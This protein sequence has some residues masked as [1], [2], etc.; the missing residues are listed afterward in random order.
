MKKIYYLF[1]FV[2]LAFTACQKEPTLHSVLPLT[3]GEQSKTLTITLQNSDYQLLPSANYASTAFS[4]KNSADAQSG[5]AAILTAEY[6]KV[7]STSTAAVTYTQSA[8]SF[9]LAD[10]VIADDS[11]TLT[12]DDYLLLPGNKYTD[13]SVSQ[14]LQWLPY[15]FPNPANNTLKLITFTIYPASTT[16]VMPY[17]FLY[18]NNKWIEI[19]T[20]QP[21][22]YTELGLGKYD[23]F[24]SS[25]QNIP[26][27]LGAL[28]NADVT[29]TDTIKKGDIVYV[30]YNYYAGSSGD[31]QRVQPLEYN[32][33][34]FEV[35][36]SFPVTINFTKK[37][38]SWA[39]V[40]PLP[41]IAHT[42]T[43][44]D[45]TLITKSTVATPSLLSN[46]AQYGDFDS[47][48]TTSYL[49]AAF[50]LVLQADYPTPVINTNYEVTFN[51]YVGGSDVATTYSYQWSGTTWVPQQQ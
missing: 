13:F 23:E 18:T 37:T 2:A 31:F 51:A 43:T 41:V 1:A 26:Q 5:I 28:V 17:S 34:N 50:V 3:S 4:F 44:A 39:Y 45:V 42:L 9:M 40:Q 20:V 12:N 35:P 19:Y 46:L 27:T 16:P 11:Y 10:S 7:A 6:P 47:G 30:S 8:A 14:L 24:T 48:W 38:G 36:F 25:V 29:I 32:G 21:T 49:N 22:Q 33:S 15:K